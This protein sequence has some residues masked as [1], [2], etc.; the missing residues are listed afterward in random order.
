[1]DKY[2]VP[3]RAN[4][5]RAR[6]YGLE[7]SF[8][9]IEQTRRLADFTLCK[10]RNLTS[11]HHSSISTMNLDQ[12]ESRYLLSGG[13]NGHICC[14][15]MLPSSLVTTHPIVFQ[16][17]RNSNR[18]HHTH[19]ICS[20][21][22]YPNDNGL[23]VTLGLDKKLKIWDTN[24]V[25]MVDEYEFSNFAYSAHMPS[26]ANASVIAVAHENGDLRLIDI[27]SGSDSHVI[28]SHTKKGICLV[29]W[30]NNNPNLLASGGVDGR[31][32]FTDV[33]S[34][35]AH[36]MSLDRDNILTNNEQIKSRQT[37][38]SS[39]A[40]HRGVKSLEFLP[41]NTHLLTVGADDLMY[42]WN[43]NNG[44]RLLVNYGPITTNNVRILTIA[45]AQMKHDRTKSVVY[46]PCGKYVRVYD[47]LTGQRLTTL[48]GHLMPVSTCI[49]NRLSVELYSCSDDIL[50]WGAVK[51]QQEDYEISMKNPERRNEATKTLAQIL[52]RDQ[53]SDDEDED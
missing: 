33:R 2:R 39:V 8:I 30:F 5:L 49:Y 40:H 20:L 48:S 29:K 53:W 32:L 37:T 36:Y 16:I 9:H 47:I 21:L 50:V 14:H 24:Q 43:V 52:N 23:F 25:K 38:V 19:N 1:M 18:D 27:R 13:S 15:D 26:T 42:L 51:K 7:T 12:S 11:Y 45:C 10:Y 22:W 17:D 34:S 35:R 41:D 3:N 44:Q 46:V 6:E 4:L 28:H 31:V